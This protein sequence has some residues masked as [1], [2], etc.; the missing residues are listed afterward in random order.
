MK[1][2]ILSLIWYFIV[3]IPWS[4]L[5][6]VQSDTLSAFYI[7]TNGASWLTKTNWMNGGDPCSPLWFGITCVSSQVSQLSI[8]S[9]SVSGT[10]PSQ[11]GQ[12][13]SLTYLDLRG[14]QMTQ[15]IPR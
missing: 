11:I 8:L 9:K 7:G 1:I 5:A 15:Q 12:L 13:S 4:I 2:N 6:D 10:L 14:H 3:T